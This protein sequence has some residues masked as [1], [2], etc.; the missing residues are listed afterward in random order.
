MNTA[1][2]PDTPG[3]PPRARPTG[4]D[5]ASA[6]GVSQATVSLVLGGKWQGRVSARTA[7]TV[8]TAARQLG[9]RPNLAAR[10]LRL[11]RTR[12]ALLVIPALAGDFFAAVHQGAVEVASA[13]D[14]G[15]LL[16]P[17]PEGISTAPDPF[18]SA[19]SALD[20]VIATSMAPGALKILRRDGL[21]LIALDSDD[22]AADA[23]VNYDIADGMRQ[24]TAHLLELG[25][26]HIAHIAAAVDSWTFAIRARALREALAQ[27]GGTLM[28]TEP[29]ALSVPAGQ[30]AATH[31]LTSHHTDG[32]PTALV[33]DD[34]LLAAGALKA[35]RRLGLRVPQD[36]S[37]TG[38]DDL[39][40]ATAVE[41]ELT[42]IRLPAADAGAAAMNALLDTLDGRRPA[43]TRLP[44]HLKART[45]TGPR[46]SHPRP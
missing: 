38:F 14:F 41:P 10:N 39:A 28:H 33:C 30:Q 25:H 5:V 8:R 23:T 36:L 19:R 29:A 26:R 16:Y 32:T 11:G 37:V 40:L 44:V 15:L 21:P 17:S 18:A 34:D 42:T 45:S 22:S 6:A 4:H 27:G 13:H 20:G 3:E 43:T 35:A 24:L 7:E 46:P 9:Y 1:T 31:V 12:T 2:N